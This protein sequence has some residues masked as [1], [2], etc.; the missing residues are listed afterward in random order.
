L[1][2]KK[3]PP[4]PAQNT[5]QIVKN[6]PIIERKK[7]QASSPPHL[8]SLHPT[9]KFQLVSLNIFFWVKFSNGAKFF[10]FLDLKLMIL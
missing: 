10:N 3:S 7:S 6:T 4:P 5:P 2:G 8:T 9:K 1:V